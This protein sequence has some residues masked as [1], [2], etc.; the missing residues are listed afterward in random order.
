MIC[1]VLSLVGGGGQWHTNSTLFRSGNRF[2]G[3]AGPALLLSKHLWRYGYLRCPEACGA[4]TPVDECVCSCPAA[5]RG[6]QSAY[7]VLAVH[8]PTMHWLAKVMEWNGMEWNA[9][10]CAGSPREWNGMECDA[11]HWLAKVMEW[12]GM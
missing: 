4:D 9:M 11:M 10:R 3:I 8:T 7:D 6:N 12:N 5:V 2:D 1:C